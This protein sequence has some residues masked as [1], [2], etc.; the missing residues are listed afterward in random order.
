MRKLLLLFTVFCSLPAMAS[1]TQQR[2]ETNI[3]NYVQEKNLVSTDRVTSL[4]MTNWRE[5]GD[6]HLIIRGRLS[7]QYLITL[8]RNCTGLRTARDIA[9]AQ[10]SNYNLNAKTDAVILPGNHSRKCYIEQIR[11]ISTDQAMELA[12]L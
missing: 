9:L 6:K 11:A 5:L 12:R 2:L 10:D 4:K 1:T 3:E 7:E 8:S